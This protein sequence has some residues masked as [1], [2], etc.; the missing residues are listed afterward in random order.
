MEIDP[1][2]T[3]EMQEP[4]LTHAVLKYYSDRA[5]YEGAYKRLGDALFEG[6]ALMT[7]EGNIRGTSTK[8]HIHCQGYTALSKNQLSVMIRQHLKEFQPES[9]QRPYSVRDKPVDA[10]GFQYMCKEYPPKVL[11][12]RGFDDTEI[13][14]LAEKSKLLRAEKKHGLREHLKGLGLTHTMGIGPCYKEYSAS[15]VIYYRDQ[16]KFTPPNFRQ[17]VQDSLYALAPHDKTW[18]SNVLDY[19]PRY[20]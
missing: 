5:D 2:A 16:G 3:P 10:Q 17:L 15:A 11:Y 9:L 18:I 6:K 4:R 7:C 14:S 12:Q 13:E 8:E 1:P 19:R 20:D